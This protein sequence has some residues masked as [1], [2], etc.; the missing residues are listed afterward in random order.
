MTYSKNRRRSRAR[1]WFERSLLLLGIAG[2]GIWAFSHISS[3]VFQYWANRILDRGVEGP[4]VTGANQRGTAGKSVAEGTLLGRLD[5]PRLHVQS[6]VREGV[7]N[8]TLSLAVGHIPGTALPGQRGNIA[9]AGHRDTFFRALRSI[10]KN[11][12]IRFQSGGN[13]YVYSVEN[14]EIVKPSDVQVL[15]SRQ[16]PELTLVTCYPFSYVGSAPDRFIVK[17]RQVAQVFG[18]V[19]DNASA[20]R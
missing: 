2:I 18:H 4:A 8:V 20:A 16:Y 6:V 3:T 17:A 13:S 5:I 11:D 1:K 19:A 12:L 14:T 9:V 7:G 10:G 15:E